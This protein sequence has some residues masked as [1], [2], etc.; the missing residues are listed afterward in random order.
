MTLLY[1]V[2]TGI[3]F[4]FLLQKARVLRYDKQLGALRLKDMT[5]VKFMLSHIIVAM[6][7]VY[8]LKDLGLVKLSLKATVLGP[9]I[10]GGLIFGLGWG[11][12]G[13]CPG[14]SAGALGEGRL[15]AVSGILGMLAGASLFAHTYP[16]LIETVYTWGNYGK[17]TLPEVFGVNHWIVL[18]GLVAVYLVI[19]RFVESKKL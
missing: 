11:L 2:L 4:G 13:Y 19:L 1:G 16:Y 17:I 7:G 15:D 8:L 10:I 18:V 12:I 6:V 14:T 9:N 3:I 5:I